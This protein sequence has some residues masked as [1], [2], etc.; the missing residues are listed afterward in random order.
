MHGNR[1]DVYCGDE[2]VIV[3]LDDL[4]AHHLN[5]PAAAVWLLHTEG[6]DPAAIA[7]ELGTNPTLVAETFAEFAHAGLL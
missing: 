5:R 6:L 4:R 3:Q 1:A 2:A 7:D